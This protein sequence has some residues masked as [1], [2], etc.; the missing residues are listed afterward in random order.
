[1]K[2]LVS[3]VF[4]LIIGALVFF[5]APIVFILLEPTYFLAAL[6]CYLVSIPL[7]IFNEELLR[8]ESWAYK[9]ILRIHV[10]EYKSEQLIVRGF[11]GSLLLLAVSL[12]VCW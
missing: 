3:I 12:S 11:G 7:I 9:K 1:M 5:R 4:L 6:A 8:V 2:K 10:L